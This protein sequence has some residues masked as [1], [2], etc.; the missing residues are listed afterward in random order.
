[1]FFVMIRRP[2]RST[3][4]DTLFP[5]TTL[6]RSDH[7]NAEE[8]HHPRHGAP[9]VAGD[10]DRHQDLEHVA[11]RAETAIGDRPRLGHVRGDDLLGAVARITKR[12]GEARSEERR[13]GQECDSPCRYRRSPYTEKKTRTLVNKHNTKNSK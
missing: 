6:F 12:S 5:Y 1:M 2:T 10:D 11:D 3:R 4:Y 13:G 7:E 8:G 9:A